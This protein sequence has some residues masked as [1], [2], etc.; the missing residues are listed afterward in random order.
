MLFVL[1]VVMTGCVVVNVAVVLV[2]STVSV[3]V[4]V[5]SPNRHEQ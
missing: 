1:T 3:T 2:T 5:V 4:G